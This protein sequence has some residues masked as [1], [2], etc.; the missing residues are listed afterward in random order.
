[1]ATLEHNLIIVLVCGLEMSKQIYWALILFVMLCSNLG[2]S[3]GWLRTSWSKFSLRN[4]FAY[5]YS[6][7]SCFQLSAESETSSAVSFSP[8]PLH[9]SELP[10]ETIYLLDAT[11]M[12][13]TSYFSREVAA[14]YADVTAQFQSRP[15]E[16]LP[17]GALVGLAMVGISISYNDFNIS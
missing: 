11:S 2:R 9:Y 15:G 8:P 12:L 14:D 5:P 4:H 16:E 13:V 10:D 6:Q 3:V 1:M 7:S 17:C